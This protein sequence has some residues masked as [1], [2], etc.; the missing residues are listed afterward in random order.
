MASLDDIQTSFQTA[1]SMLADF[2]NATLKQTPSNSSGTVST[3][4]I[5]QTGFV[6]VTGISV[7]VGGA[8]GAL[9]DARAVGDIATT[10]KIYEVGITPGFYP[11]NLVFPTGLAYAPGAAQEAAIMYTRI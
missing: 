8:V 4:K 5:I 1:N 3:T 9:H 6:R 2:V 11:V 7:V 10:N